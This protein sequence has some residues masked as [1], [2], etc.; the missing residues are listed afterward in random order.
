METI[1]AYFER[2]IFINEKDG[3]GA[4]SFRYGTERAVAIGPYPFHTAYTPLLL[5]GDWR[6]TEKGRE[7]HLQ[8]AR[9]DIGISD[10]RYLPD[11]I[12]QIDKGMKREKAKKLVEKGFEAFPGMGEKC[13]AY[14]KEMEEYLKTF[15]FL[16]GYGG[17]IPETQ[18]VYKAFRGKP[19]SGI[20]IMAADP[21]R[22]YISGLIR[23]DTARKIA[24][25]YMS[26]SGMEAA[27]LRC[28]E[29]RGGDV[30]SSMEEIEK[31]IRKAAPD[32]EYT[33]PEI[34]TGI[35]QSHSL[36]I[37]KGVCYK[38]AL[39]DDEKAAAA[40]FIRLMR[41]RK[42]IPYHP[43]IIERVE[44]EN[45][46]AFGNQQRQAF[47]LLESTGIRLLTGDPG[48]GK[49]T[50]LNGM[51]RYLELVYKKEY[52]YIPVIKLCAPS[53]RAAQRM[54][55][56]TGREAKTVHKLL[57]INPNMT[58]RRN[59][60]DAD[61]VVVDEAS[62]LGISMFRTLEEAVKDGSLL[63]LVGDINQLPS[64][65]E[66]T[67]LHDLIKSGYLDQCN[68]T[69][70]FRQAAESRININAKKIMKGDY[71]LVE[72]ADFHAEEVA[73]SAMKERM[74]QEVES[75]IREAG[76]K[77]RVQVLAPVK[78]GS[79]GVQEGNKALQKIFNPG[80]G[81]IWFGDMNLRKND[82]VIFLKNNY[83]AG[84]F[85]GDVGYIRDLTWT[86]LTIDVDGR[87]LFIPQ[88]CYGD[89]GLAYECTVHK[90]Q[91]SEYDYLLVVLQKESLPIMTKNLL[92]TA[93]TRGKEKVV[94]L[95]E[96]GILQK[97]VAGDR[98]EKERNS[99]LIQRIKA[100]CA[101]LAR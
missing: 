16:S 71:F 39:L 94:I 67:V 24:D 77:D 69:E 3:M 41:T 23:F 73:P 27:L 52:G 57:G 19:G 90:S 7:F 32:E 81:G 99:F 79:C 85:N 58:G 28:M 63:L 60:L 64:V 18:R 17:T 35:E 25:E 89:I 48:S 59:M 1:E 84:Y 56:A 93:V 78:K 50:T 95:Y 53:G 8:T 12:M 55:E 5:E 61:I 21:Y 31:S 80:K 37:D 10:K 47:H 4:F 68:L 54:K 29:N 43:E 9:I 6:V 46:H 11:F 101:K 86:S 75:L 66:G 72:G 74:L 40:E 13:A 92:Y 87:I 15:Y 97:T 62:M 22:V 98:K 51:L 30:F 91:G 14:L 45:G 44:A 76:D 42:K 33:E 38:K 49:T 82:R 83:S 2:R 26:G 100:E 96:D 88:E 36:V 70:V 65:E 20:R 34:V